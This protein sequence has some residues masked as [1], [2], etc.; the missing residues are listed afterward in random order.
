[1]LAGMFT[2]LRNWL[3]TFVDR[4]FKPDSGQH[5]LTEDVTLTLDQRVAML[6]ARISRME[7]GPEP[8]TYDEG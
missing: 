6:E 3:Q 5:S 1:M 8:R 2:P 7:V 4:R